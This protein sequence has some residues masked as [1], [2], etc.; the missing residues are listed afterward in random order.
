MIKKFTYNNPFETYATVLDIE[1]SKSDLLYFSKA[2]NT[3]T[4]NMTDTTVVYGLGE[5]VRGITT[6]ANSR[7]NDNLYLIPE[8]YCG[9]Y[10]NQITI[11]PDGYIHGCASEVS[12]EDYDTLA[13]GNVKRESLSSLITKGKSNCLECNCKQVDE[14]GVVNFLNCTCKPL[15]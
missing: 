4:Y 8:M 14:N 3:F 13:V 10:E 15:D 12:S 7:V 11:T 1:E 2:E 5:A 6:I 9:K